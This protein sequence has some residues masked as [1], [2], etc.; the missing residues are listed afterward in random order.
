MAYIKVL[1]D[2]DNDGNNENDLVITIAW[3]IHRNRQAKN[4]PH[5]DQNKINGVIV[6]NQ[7]YKQL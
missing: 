7:I 2:D 1:H 5:L 4:G 3:L 6:A